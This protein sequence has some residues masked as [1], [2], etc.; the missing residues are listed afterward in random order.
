MSAI[1]SRR[2]L[3][4]SEEIDKLFLNSKS[5]VANSLEEGIIHEKYHAK[6]IMN[7]NYPQ[8]EALYDERSDIHID[9]ISK[10]AYSDGA[11][12]IA[13]VGVLIER[14]E[15]DIPQNALDLFNK[16]IGGMK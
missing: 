6:L 15:K 16:Y 12:C 8:V 7:L 9:G 13:E 5:T 10:I 3:N 11:E 14:G 2:S 1:S 4:C